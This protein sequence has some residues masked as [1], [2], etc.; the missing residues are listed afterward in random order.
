MFNVEYV[1]KLRNYN[2][3]ISGGVFRTGSKQTI[4]EMKVKRE[5]TGGRGVQAGC[6]MMGLGTFK[7]REGLNKMKCA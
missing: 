7:P 1:W 2:R 4:G 6:G 5:I 3:N